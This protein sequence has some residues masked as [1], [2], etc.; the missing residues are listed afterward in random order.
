MKNSERNSRLTSSVSCVCL[1]NEK[2][3]FFRDGPQRL[4]LPASP[5]IL[6]AASGAF[7]LINSVGNM[8]GWLGPG[9]MGWLLQKTGDYHTG[10]LVCA[11][12]A[13]LSAASMAA[14]SGSLIRK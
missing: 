11:G 13:L 3:K 10:L 9:V 1:I 5:K 7:A 4:F 14:L 12:V 6:P 2:S 8:S